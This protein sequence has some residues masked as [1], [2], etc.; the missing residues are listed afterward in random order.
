MFHLNKVLDN[1]LIIYP[2]FC[3]AIAKNSDLVEFSLHWLRI[4]FFRFNVI[5][6]L[7]NTHLIKI[8]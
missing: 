7:Q 8:V 5:F 6:P 4:I 1:L 3:L 2:N